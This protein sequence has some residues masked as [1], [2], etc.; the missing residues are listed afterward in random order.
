MSK[1]TLAK[2]LALLVA[3]MG[4]PM[5]ALCSSPQTQ[6]SLNTDVPSDF[7]PEGMAWDGKHRQFLLGSIRL[8]RVD[9]V[10]P[11][12]GHSRPFATAPGSV[13]GLQ[14]TPDGHELWGVWTSFGKG[15]NHNA[16]TGIIAW[17]LD[18]GHRLG[19]WPLADKDP[20]VNLGDLLMVDAHSIVTTDSGTGA[21][22]V[23]DRQRKTYR[24]IVPA[25]QFDSPQGIARGRIPG[26]VYM[27]EYS[28][29]IWRITL[30]NGQRQHLVPSDKVLGLDGLYRAG[31]TLIAVQNGTKIPRILSIELGKD[32]TIDGV[33]IL[34]A[35]RK[36]WSGP[37]LGAV[38]G[39]RFWFNATGQWDLFDD[40]LRPVPKAHLQPVLLD[41]VVIAPAALKQS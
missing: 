23:F 21:V 11:R 34:A 35:G 30:N 15:F 4:L 36:T 3:L 41:S 12:S 38:V 31:D 39:D 24:A 2:A 29:G 27:A 6:T 37:T 10:D 28:T 19:A 9:V 14:I 5:A 33:A 7:L 8:H 17:S 40:E 32:D 18:D 22:Y 1:H 26:T 20:R 16:S 25:G 13:L